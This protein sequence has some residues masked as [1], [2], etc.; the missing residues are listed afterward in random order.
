MRELRQRQGPNGL[1]KVTCGRTPGSEE[2]G[3]ART[4]GIRGAGRGRPL[5]ST[6]RPRWRRRAQAPSRKT[7][8][9]PGRPA[10]P[11]AEALGWAGGG[12][13][14]EGASWLLGAGAGLAT[15]PPGRE[16]AG[17]AAAPGRSAGRAGPTGRAVDVAAALPDRKFPWSWLRQG[18]GRAGWN[19][20]VFR[21]LGDLSHLLAMILLLGK[22]WRSKC[23]KGEGGPR[24]EVG[25]PGAGAGL[26]H[27]T[28]PDQPA[29]F[30]GA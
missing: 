15:S 26:G 19:M 18:A 21:I 11:V 27:L 14:G 7:P 16:S 8:A 24:R 30:G 20:N 12:T 22:I 5:A 6:E 25:D 3:R 9:R 1:P 17:G 23:C 10:R 2:G 4:P 28:S 29:E 13:S